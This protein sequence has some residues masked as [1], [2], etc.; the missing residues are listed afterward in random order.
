MALEEER[1]VETT[2][3]LAVDGRS[4][5]ATYHTADVER[6]FLPLLDRLARVHAE[7]CHRAQ[8]GGSAG[9]RTVVLLAAPPGAG[10]STLAATLE[11]LAAK[12]PGFPGLQALGM[13]GFH[14]PNAYLETHSATL[15]SGEEVPLRSIKGAPETFD[16]RALIERVR[17]I[18]SACAPVKWP[19]YSRIMHDVVPDSLIVDAPIVLIEG[20]YLLLDEEPWREL[21]SLCDFTIF[22]EADRALLRER[23]IARK[24][25]GGMA[26]EDAK[27]FFNASDGKNVARVLEA[28]RPADA[29]LQLDAHGRVRRMGATPA[30][31]FFDIDGTLTWDHDGIPHDQAA[32]TSRVRRAIERFVDEGN[33]A[34]LCT[35][36]PPSSVSP[37]VLACPFTATIMLAGGYVRYRDKVVREVCIPH[38]VLC[39]LVDCFER[40]H[41]PALLET[42][43]GGIILSWPDVPSLFDADAGGSSRLGIA[44]VRALLEEPGKLEVGKVVCDSALLDRLA[45]AREFIDEYFVVS[46]LGIGAHELTVPAIN[47]FEG[48]RAIW[49]ALRDDGI[50]FGTVYGFGDSENDITMLSAVDTAVVMGNALPAARACADYLTDAVQDDGV[51]TA[52]EHFGFI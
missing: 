4:V 12:E 45:F 8:Q 32:P 47:K 38:D 20:N 1:R 15:S 43:S 9:R 13:D 19:A 14:Y 7:R 27:A 42:V 31:A 46:D 21:A 34:V 22:I 2:F 37:G 35:G 48:M 24:M 50:A 28:R 5:M 39:K 10:K 41:M 3:Q 49:R 6:V 52:L 33:I 30:V 11:Y 29:C 23:L 36:R 18:R 40:A 26:R 16:V 44:E 51:A 17:T 25:R